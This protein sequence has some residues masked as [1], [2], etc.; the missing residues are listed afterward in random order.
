MAQ[1]WGDMLIAKSMLQRKSTQGKG[2]HA[3]PLSCGAYFDAKH[4]TTHTPNLDPSEYTLSKA[5]SSVKPS[6]NRRVRH[7]KPVKIAVYADMIKVTVPDY[8]NGKH[9]RDR[10]NSGGGIRGNIS[11]FSRASRKRMIEF[12]AQVR[13]E[14]D[15]YFVTMTYDDDSWICH[16]GGHQDQWEAFRRRFERAY[17]GCKAIWRVELKERQSGL[18]VGQLVP[19]FHM[20]IWTGGYNTDENKRKVADSLQSWGVSAWGEILETENPHFEKYGFHVEPVRTRKRAYA[21][22]SKYIGKIDDDDVQC[23][24]RWGR[25][26]RFDRSYSEIV[27]LTEDEAVEFKRI[28]KKWLRGR[29]S[30]YSNVISKI[31]ADVGYC[32]FGLGDALTGGV[33]V[34]INCGV[35]RLIW[36]A[37]V[38]AHDKYGGSSWSSG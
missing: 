36:H 14:G 10:S 12:M 17:P 2:H 32:V 24:R 3:P 18:L 26:G 1:E 7:V 11:G 37:Q 27:S 19:H 34:T 35:G 38:I 16:W 33:V 4:E 20:L 21:Y 31:S 25:I 9:A 23:G 13:D 6:Q 8:A 29:K 28:I 30:R 15:L 22:V 5:M